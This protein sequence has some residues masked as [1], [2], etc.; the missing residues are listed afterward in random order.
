[1]SNDRR[2]RAYVRFDGSGRVIPGSMVLRK[3]KPK[4]GI[5]QEIVSYQCCDDV[6]INFVLASPGLTNATLTLSCNGTVIGAPME[7]GVTTVTDGD[8]LTA[9][10]TAFSAFGVFTNPS[11]TNFSLTLS[12]EQKTAL[13]PQGTLSFSVAAA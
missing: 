3:Q 12:R 1:M 6:T 10:N 5:W 13:C 2:L 8:V 9:L 11:A 7:T 4:V